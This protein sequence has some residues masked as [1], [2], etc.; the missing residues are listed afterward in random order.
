M[1]AKKEKLVFICDDNGLTNAVDYYFEQKKRSL[2]MYRNAGSFL[3]KLSQYT[4]DTKICIDNS[5]KPEMSSLALA[6][7][8]H[9]AGYTKLYLLSG[10]NFENG[11]YESERPPA[12]YELPEYLTAIYKDENMLEF[13]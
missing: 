4:K 12:P 7:R 9:E 2:D 6:K 11:K 3:E 8:L 5:I 1:E 10:W 13:F